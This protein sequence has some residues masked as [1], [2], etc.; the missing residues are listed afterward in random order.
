MN[1]PQRS[2]IPPPCTPPSFKNARPPESSFMSTGLLSKR[3]KP[4]LAERNHFTAPRTPCKKQQLQS[5]FAPR[6][7]S[8]NHSLAVTPGG[9][10]STL[11]ESPLLTTPCAQQASYFKLRNS[12]SSPIR[13]RKA[14]D[15]IAASLGFSP[16]TR[17]SDRRLRPLFSARSPS[18]T[19]SLFPW[20]SP[21][22]RY[23]S[24][25]PSA[26][27][28]TESPFGPQS[29]C[30][31]AAPP[32]LS[33]FPSSSPFFSSSLGENLGRPSSFY[34]RL[35]GNQNFDYL[36]TD[37]ST[38]FPHFLNK[39]YFQT[40]GKDNVNEKTSGDHTDYFL[41][42]FHDVTTLGTGE[43]SNVYK[44][45]DKTSGKYYAVK[46]S[47]RKFAGI[48]DRDHLEEVEILW[49]L[50]QHPHCVEIISAWEQKG[51]LYLQFELCECGSLFSFIEE[52]CAQKRMDEILIWKILTDI[53]LVSNIKG[54]K[55]I[56]DN[57]VIHL[58]IKPA[59]I[60]IS[61]NKT[62][63][64]GDFGLATQWPAPD[65]ID[66]EGDREYIAREVLNGYY[67]KS[68]DVFSLG[69]IILEIAAN[70]VL[71]DNGPEWQK[72]R[73]G[74]LSDCRFGS[75]SEVLIKF[76]Q[77]MLNPNPLNRP[78]VETILRHP[79]IQFIIRGRVN[80]VFTRNTL[81]SENEKTT[82]KF[83]RVVEESN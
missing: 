56:H 21:T 39:E 67:E 72:L 59:N 52:H 7:S 37:V 29:P 58:D 20:N 74:D 12:P 1:T 63:K 46:Q 16:L 61:K 30:S 14:S 33:P 70:I 47:K 64:I 68:V 28:P 5:P 75:I 9:A 60:F 78:T 27:Q 42:Q 24:Q 8:K 76:I 40:S 66:R 62:L 43:F 17:S 65:D 73:A 53:A 26:R 44:V 25:S 34:S 79:V 22:P 32:S 45:K 48:K 41:A 80:G 57:D 35:Y 82:E 81:D 15:S 3:N 36:Q 71:P 49:K 11:F 31:A 10:P 69:L 23:Q 2:T 77:Q 54:L 51:T 6:L 55:H 18:P 83:M 38:P 13:T 19:D 50:G 4:R